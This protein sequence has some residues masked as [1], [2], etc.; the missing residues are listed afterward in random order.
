[1]GQSL[2]GDPFE[3]TI[4]GNETARRLS[5]LGYGGMAHPARRGGR[6]APMPSIDRRRF[7]NA[8]T[9]AAASLYAQPGPGQARPNVIVFFTDQQRWDTLG[10][11]GSPMGLTPNLDRMARNGVRFEHAFTS[12]PVC[13]PARSTLQT[14]KYPTSTGVISNSQRL[15]DDELTLAHY[16]GRQKYQTGYIGKWHLAGTNGIVPRERRGGYQWWAAS[17]I[18]EFTSSANEGH[19]FDNDDRAIDFKQYRVDFL[20]DLAIR[21]LRQRNRAA[22]FFLFVSYLEP[23]HQNN[24]NRFVAP[25][26][27]ADRYR[28]N[29][30][31]PPDLAPFPG[32]WKSQLPDYYGIIA[33][34]DECFGRLM[35]ELDDER[36]TDN[37]VVVFASDHGCHFRTR[38]SEYKRSCHEAS[39]H[40]PMMVQGPGFSPGR[41]VPELV[42]LVDL[43]P[44][45]LDCAGIEIPQAMEGRSLLN[46]ARGQERNWRNEIF[47]QMR[48]EAL[49]RAIRTERWK[50]CIFDPDSKAEDPHSTNYTE[51]FLYDLFSDPHEHVNLIGRPAF[52]RIA[53]EL[54]DRLTARMAEIR[55]PKPVVTSA[56]FY[57]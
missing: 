54:R 24:L 28:D 35:S 31:I 43:P 44:T 10:S 39:I 48:E 46:L 11:N 4:Q 49:Q 5:F 9:G 34:I 36:L 29:F 47:V 57:A 20:T 56:R 7:L 41:T 23:H 6:I 52:R 14:G 21:F 25:D 18:L 32:D 17:N 15:R 30:R 3:Q 8:S 13:A 50:Y 45:L 27:Y 51:R 33:R 2:T 22:P 53:D 1:M 26:G 19:V 37:T 12:Q 42:S 38:N 16:F 55:E 40:I